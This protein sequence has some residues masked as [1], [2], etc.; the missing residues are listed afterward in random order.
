MMEETEKVTLVVTSCDRHDL[1]RRTLESFVKFNTYPIHETIIV[2]DSDRAIPIDLFRLG[3]LGNVGL[4]LNVQ[5]IGQIPSIDRAY[6]QVQTPY[7]FHCEDD[8]EFHREGFI[9]QS[10]QILE[11]YPEV[12]Q[13][14][15]REDSGHLALKTAQYPFFT[16]Q[17]DWAGGWSGFSFNPGL[18]RLC[19]YKKIGNYVDA[20][21]GCQQFGCESE[22]K[23]S[24][25]YRSMGFIAASLRPG[26]VKHIGERRSRAVEPPV[27]WNKVTA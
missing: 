16:M 4:L 14:W 10:M 17:L 6:A 1:L 12:M 19:D 27:M 24:R 3:G 20:T 7:I 8:W 22:L 13:V 15:L 23:L 11:S 2:E 26:F 18:R 9:E 25:L 21:R 5:R